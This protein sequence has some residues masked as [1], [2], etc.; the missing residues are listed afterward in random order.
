MM[1]LP[2]RTVVQP[3][4][5]DGPQTGF[6]ENY[7]AA[8]KAIKLAETTVSEK[9]ILAEIYDPWVREMN[10]IENRPAMQQRQNP[11]GITENDPIQFGTPYAR[12]SE[13]EALQQ[14][15]AAIAEYPD[16]S[17][18][19]DREANYQQARD[20]ARAALEEQQEIAS[21]AGAAGTLGQFAGG[22]AGELAYEPFVQAS[23]FVGAPS[24]ARALYAAMIEGFIGAGAAVVTTPAVKDW[25]DEIGMPMSDAEVWQRIGFSAAGGAGFVLGLRGIMSGIG[26]LRRAGARVNV[27]PELEAQVEQILDVQD[28]NP[29]PVS[30]EAEHVARLDAAEQSLDLGIPPKMPEE[31]I[32]DIRPFTPEELQPRTGTIHQFDP[33]ELEVDAETFQYKSGGDVEGVTDRLQGIK[34]WNPVQAGVILVYERADGTRVVA[35]GHQRVGLAKRLLPDQPDIKIYG[36]ILREVDGVTPT[37]ARVQAALKNIAEAPDVGA[38][39][40]IDAAKVL[41]I[42]PSRLKNLPPRSALVRTAREMIP[43]SDDTFLMVVN[44]LVDANHA[45][46][47]GRLIPDN[48]ELQKA[49][50]AVLA[51]D[52]PASALEADLMVRQVLDIGVSRETQVGLFGEEEVVEALIKERAKILAGAVREM[53]KDKAAFASLVRNQG[54]LE[55]AGNVVARDASITQEKQNAIALEIIQKQATRKGPIAE[56]LNQAARIAK[57]T[58]SYAGPTSEVVGAIR[59][60][61]AR[62]DFEGIDVGG[63]GRGAEIE[64]QG[65][66]LLAANAPHLADF[67]APGGRGQVDQGAN[68]TRDLE[69]RTR[70]EAMQP[71]VALREDLEAQINEGAQEPQIIRHPAIVDAIE[72]ADSIPETHR[73]PNYLSDEWRANREFTFVDEDAASRTQTKIIGY[74]GAV[75]ELHRRARRFLARSGVEVAQER[76]AT[77]VLGPPASGKSRIAEEIQTTDQAIIIDADDVKKTLS[78]Y[79]GGIGANAVH[80]ESSDIMLEVLDAAMAAGDNLV[81]PK[82]GFRSSSIAKMIGLL[83]KKGYSVNVLSMKVDYPEAFRRMIR[84]FIKTGRLVNPTFMRSVGDNPSQ[85]YYT[86]KNEGKADGFAEIDNNDA[87]TAPRK[88]LDDDDDLLAAYGGLLR[89]PGG[90]GDQPLAPAQQRERARSEEIDLAALEAESLD[91]PFPFAERVDEATGEN[92]VDYTTPRQILAEHDADQAMLDRL[93]GCL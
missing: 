3:D 65:D 37:E 69:E 12:S 36:H 47:V 57:A 45:S 27:D 28:S 76:K 54:R 62:G 84:R 68:L 58:G 59:D 39:M 17:Q 11:F 46:A 90:A 75:K 79:E 4:L 78:E 51:Q 14:L 87:P 34:T 82:V 72:R 89:R 19:Y 66:F 92:V 49:A 38:S 8:M 86:L 67:D 56:T 9:R 44:G 35:D 26:A 13:E 85:T 10:R 18:E 70:R 48:P 53:R 25:R 5:Y 77:I 20:E 63:I 55:E 42:D 7:N 6:V 88:I 1:P 83:K 74:D 15:E 80:E 50:M 60:A 43:L 2:P 73:A 29:L 33:L 61:V 52:P 32:A 16:L 71:D 21:R 23:L 30:A 81:L 24:A 64:E 31:P 93:E 91:S 22:M 40:A 41:R